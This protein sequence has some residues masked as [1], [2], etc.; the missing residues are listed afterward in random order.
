M[1]HVRNEVAQILLK[2]LL[3]LP[4]RVSYGLVLRKAPGA[5]EVWCEKNRHLRFRRKEM[6]REKNIII[7]Y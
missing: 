5:Y 4:M 7:Q 6:K 1:V 2:I 3:P